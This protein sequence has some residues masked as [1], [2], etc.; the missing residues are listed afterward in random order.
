[1][2]IFGHSAGSWSASGHVLS[3]LS[4]G[5]FKR[6]IMQSCALLNDKKRGLITTTEALATSKVLAQKVNCTGDLWLDCLKRVDAF[7]IRNSGNDFITYPL[8][9]GTTFLPELAMSAFG[10]GHF[11]PGI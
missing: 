5:L 6:A 9:D 3:P 1:V 2:T 10:H 8:E 7:A 11:N 4:K